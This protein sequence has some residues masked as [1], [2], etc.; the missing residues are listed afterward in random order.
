MPQ[1]EFQS[2][3]GRLKTLQNSGGTA[4]EIAFQSLIGRLKTMK[5]YSI[6]LWEP[7]FQSLIGR[8]KTSM[9]RCSFRHRPGVSIPYR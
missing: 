2:L 9:L 3:I 8:L 7:G 5:D 6:D 1:L 4:E